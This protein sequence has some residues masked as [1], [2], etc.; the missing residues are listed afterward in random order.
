M[1]ATHIILTYHYRYS[2]NLPSGVELYHRR[3][4]DA[5]KFGNCGQHVHAILCWCGIPAVRD[6]NVS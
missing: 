4:P 3:V 1:S 2:L 6:C 5:R